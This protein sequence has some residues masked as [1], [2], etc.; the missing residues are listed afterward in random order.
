MIL[1]I[2][3]DPVNQMVVSNLLQPLGYELRQ[4]MNG[5]EAMQ[6]EATADGSFSSVLLL[7]QRMLDKSDA[8]HKRLL[9]QT[10]AASREQI[11]RMCSGL[12]DELT[13]TA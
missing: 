10:A 8:A 4:A 6:P 2:D 5:S 3:D 13:T 12:R 11:E 7:V 9:E 1:S